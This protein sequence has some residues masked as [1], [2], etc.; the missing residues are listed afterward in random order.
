MSIDIRTLFIRLQDR[1]DEQPWAVAAFNAR[2]GMVMWYPRIG[3]WVERG[4]FLAP[5]FMLYESGSWPISEDEATDLVHRGV[6]PP[7]RP[8]SGDIITDDMASGLPTA[9]PIDTLIRPSRANPAD[10]GAA[11]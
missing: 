11:G 2:A 4:H 5:Y 7:G 1:T 8:I 9:P 10:D 6:G 3:K